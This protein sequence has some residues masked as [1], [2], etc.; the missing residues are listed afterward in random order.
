MTKF[1]ESK[2][3]NALH[4]EKAEV[5]KEYWFADSIS[6]LKVCVESNMV[7][8]VFELGAVKDC[9]YPFQEKD[10]DN[11][12]QFIYPYEESSEQR[13]T[14]RQLAEWLAKGN[15][16]YKLNDSEN[17]F[18]YTRVS[19]NERIDDEPVYEA[20]VIRSWGSEEW[21]EPTYEVYLRDCKH[22]SQDELEDTPYRDG[23]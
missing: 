16:Q 5:G 2:V 10:K 14:N 7:S 13:M 18:A 9:D 20:Y 15:G 4:P 21:I 8:N 12:T 11:Y 22:L 19:Y 23:C 3:I 6:F 1:D 17:D